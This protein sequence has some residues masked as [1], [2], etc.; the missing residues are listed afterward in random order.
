MA[1]LYGKIIDGSFGRY[2]KRF[3]EL[4][5]TSEDTAV[6][7]E[8]LFPDGKG[9]WDSKALRE[10]LNFGVVKKAPGN[11]YYLNEK[12][13]SNSNAVL[14]QRL[15]LVG[16]ALVIGLVLGLLSRYGIIEI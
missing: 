2:Y 11:K 13:A 1:N 15:I 3:R 9:M 8:T 16:I 12:L 5:A 6:T 10:M 4:H 14:K 7:T